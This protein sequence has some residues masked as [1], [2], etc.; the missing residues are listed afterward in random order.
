M[1]FHACQC[2][3]VATW[4]DERNPDRRAWRHLTR[5]MKKKG[6]KMICFNGNKHTPAGFSGLN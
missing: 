2:G 1:V 5:L 3:A 6:V 4:E